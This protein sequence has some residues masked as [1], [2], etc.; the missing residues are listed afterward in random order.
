ML[1]V[2][3]CC[4]INY[5]YKFRLKL[6]NQAEKQYLTILRTQRHNFMNDFQVIYG[7]IQLNKLE[8]A[9]EYIQQSAKISQKLSSLLKVNS[10][11]LTALFLY[12]LEQAELKEVKVEFE[13]LEEFLQLRENL[14]PTL[15]A[16]RS[17]FQFGLEQA[18]KEK[19]DRL[20][21][22]RFAKV[23]R[24]YGVFCET[25]FE[26]CFFPC[27]KPGWLNNKLIVWKTIITQMRIGQN[28]FE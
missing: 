10:P 23:D 5:R 16:Y 26:N 24:I 8:K 14:E 27:A 21:Y 18:S 15:Y 25:G 22:L 13:F 11:E 7:Y 6:L 12:F 9:L 2:L 20:I 1:F 4:L 19:E 3:L 28:L 17:A